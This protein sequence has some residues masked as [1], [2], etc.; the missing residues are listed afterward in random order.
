[1]CRIN[2]HFSWVGKLEHSIHVQT[3]T[4]NTMSRLKKKLAACTVDM[5]DIDR[6][7]IRSLWSHKIA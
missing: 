1:M 4:K 3:L 2:A 5:I 7:L 6:Q